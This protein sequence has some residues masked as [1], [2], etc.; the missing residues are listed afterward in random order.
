MGRPRQYTEATG[1][2]LLNAAERLVGAHGVGALSVRAVSAEVG[3]TT[4]AIYSVFGSKDDLVAA[5]AARTFDMLGAAVAAL[6]RTSDPA[7]DLIDAGA[8]A[9]RNLAIDHPVLFAL[10][11]QRVDHGSDHD[12]RIEAAAHGAWSQLRER[13]ARLPAVSDGNDA[14]INRVATAFH[15]LCE[16]LAALELRGVIT[17]STADELW[18]DALAALV[19]GLVS[20]PAMRHA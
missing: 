3:T 7:Q 18:R 4:R 14:Q 2:E 8:I 6:P 17:S 16:G 13:V 11:I 12:H 9:F 1:V 5:L 19:T 10:G 15:A 20:A